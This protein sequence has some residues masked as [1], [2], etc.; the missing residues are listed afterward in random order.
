MLF[1]RNTGSTII[2]RIP[3][4]TW[5]RRLQIYR[6]ID[7]LSYYCVRPRLTL[8]TANLHERNSR[9]YKATSHWIQIGQIR[10]RWIT[11]TIREGVPV[12]DR[13]PVMDHFAVFPL[14]LDPRD[15]GADHENLFSLFDVPTIGPKGAQT[16]SSQCS[17]QPRRSSVRSVTSI[18]KLKIFVSS[19]HSRTRVTLASGMGSFCHH[20]RSESHLSPQKRHRNSH[21]DRRYGVVRN[22]CKTDH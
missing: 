11:E 1:Q 4:K 17:W 8:Q 6:Y 14:P 18:E 9:T 20:T 5:N 19:G 22:F 12:L 15:D 2:R 3:R 16:P 13:W 21:G 10:F 7:H